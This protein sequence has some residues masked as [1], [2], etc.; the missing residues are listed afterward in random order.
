MW[1]WWLLVGLG[2]NGT[3]APGSGRRPFPSHLVAVYRHLRAGLNP[4]GRGFD[5][6]IGDSP[7]TREGSLACCAVTTLS[8][9]TR[10]SR[11]HFC[12]SMEHDY[13]ELT[14]RLERAYSP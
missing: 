1:L 13:L 12:S 8:P 5:A 10:S 14:E 9:P 6:L 3:R 7:D 11:G 2:A 4:K